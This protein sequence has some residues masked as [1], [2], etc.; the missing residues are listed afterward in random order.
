MSL[1]TAK[2]YL[3]QAQHL[4][5]LNRSSRAVTVSDGDPLLVQ[6]FATLLNRETSSPREAML[7]A[8]ELQ[9]ELDTLIAATEIDPPEGAKMPLQAI[10]P[11]EPPRLQRLE[12]QQPP[13]PKKR[14]IWVRDSFDE[15]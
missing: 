11:P 10:Q 3:A 9:R 6:W 1:N 5:R 8:L 12:S 2:R 7:Q 14:R 13:A 4:A 15:A